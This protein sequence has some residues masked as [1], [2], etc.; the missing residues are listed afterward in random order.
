VDVAPPLN[1]SQ[2]TS[3]LDATSFL[4]TGANP[5]QTGVVSGT[6]ERRR[7]AVLR[8]RVLRR[9][10]S[11][12]PGVHISILDHP[13][14]GQTLTRADGMFD[15]A[16]N[17]GGWLTV[18]YTQ[19]GYLPAQRKVEAPWQEY[20][21]L[22]EVILIQEDAQVTL[23]DLNADLPMQVARGSVITDS[24]GVRQE[25]LFFPQGTTAYMSF[26][27][28]VTQTLTS[29]HVRI[30]E[31][32]VG[33]DG[34]KRMP[35]ELP[36]NSAY[37]YAAEYS[38]DEARAAG[39]QDVWFNPPIIS[40]V[41]NYLSFTVGVTIPMGYYDNDRGAWI[42]ADSGRVVKIVSVTDGRAD[43]DID[44]SGAPA[45]PAA[46]AALGVTDA[47]RAQLAELYAVGESLWR[48]P[49]PHFTR[50]W[51][52]NQGT[53]C[54]EPCP[55]PPEPEPCESAGDNSASCESPPPPP[56]DP[57]IQCGSVIGC[58]NQTLG[59]AIGV[60]GAPFQLHYQ[61][62][63][64]VGYHVPNVLHIPL[65][66]ET[67]SP[68]LQYIQLSVSVAGRRFFVPYISREQRAYQVIWDGKDAAGR[69]VQGRQ[70]VQVALTYIYPLVYRPTD[71]FGYNGNSAVALASDRAALEFGITKRWVGWIGAWRPPVQDLGGWT[72][73]IHHA[74]DPQGKV[75]Y[76]GTGE[77]RS[78][79]ALNGNVIVAAAGTGQACN[80]WI[81]CVEG[82]PATQSRLL[83][84]YGVEFSA[85]GSFYIA[86]HNSST[87]RI[88]RVDASGI[89]TTAAGG[90]TCEENCEG[91]LA[92]QVDLDEPVAVGLAADGSFYIAEADGYAPFRLLKVNKDGTVRTVAGAGPYGSNGDGGPAT[93]ATIGQVW[94]VVVAPD[95]AVYFA[96]DSGQARI[97]RIG[98]DG[99][100]TTVAGG[101]GLPPT[102]G[103]VPTEL[104]TP[105][106][107]SL[108]LGSDGR[109][110]FAFF[111]WNHTQIGVVD[112]A[113]RYFTVARG[114]I[115]HMALGFDG[116]I[117]YT[118][119]NNVYRVSAIAPDG[120]LRTVA[121]SGVRCLG[122]YEG[123]H[124]C[125]NNGP[126]LGAGFSEGLTGIALAPD[127]SLYVA[128]FIQAQVRQIK[129]ALPGVGV[130]DI[131]I[132]STD[133]AQ[134]YVFNA[135]GRHLRTLHGLTG[136]LLYQFDYDSAGRLISVTDGDNNITAITRDG[137]GNPTGILA[138]FGQTTTFA[139]NANGYLAAVTNPANETI[140]LSYTS[141]GLLTGF[142][143]PLH[144]LHTFE[145]DAS[146]RLL[147]DND[148]AA[149]A[150]TLARSAGA[151]TYTVTLTTAL[152][153][154]TY[155]RVEALP[156]DGQRRVNTGPAGLQEETVQTNDGTS[157]DRSPTGVTQNATLGPDPRWGMLA[158]IGKT[159]VITTPGGLNASL[160]G[161]RTAT[162]AQAGDPFSLTAL[163]EIFTV[164]NRTY[165]SSYDTATRTF[166]DASPAGRQQTT[167][168]DVLGRP[169][170]AQ[171]PGLEA[172]TYAY[173]SRG[174]LTAVTQGS[175]PA[176]RSATFAYNSDSY[177]ASIADPLGRTVSFAYDL[178]GRVTTQTLPD[179]RV[180]GYAYDANGNLTS[181]TPPGRPAHTFTYTPV[182]LQASYTPPDIG[183][184]ATATG[185]T[186]NLDRQLTRVTRPDGKTIE[187][188]YDFA[189]RPQSLTFSRGSL[190][191]AYHPTTGNLAGV[192]APGGVSLT[193][194]YD[195]SL[196][197]DQTWTGP[198]AGSVGYIYDNSFRRA[199]LSVNGADAIAY[200]Y[201][202]DSLLTGAGGLILSR[203]AQNGLLVG[204]GLGGVTDAFG[205][206]G[207]G[208]PISYTASF[209]GG[210]LLGFR[211]EYDKLG[212]IV[213]RTETI[214]GAADVYVYGY[215]LAGR[216][217]TVR[218]NGAS[219]STYTYDA[220]GNRLSFTGAGGPVAGTYDAQDRLLIYGNAVYTYSANGELQ[221][222]T[223]GGQSATYAYDELGNLTAFSLPDGTQI[224]YV[225]DGLNRRIGKRVNGVLVQGF[226]YDGQLRIVAELDGAG[227]V[228][229]RFVYAT[230]VN[231]PDYMVKGGVTWRLLTDHLGS[232]RLVVDAATGAVAQAMSFDEFGRVLSD[233][234]P[235]FQP[236][237]FAG[238]LYDRHTGLVRF[239]ARDY[240]AEVGRWTAKD[241]IGFED[242][243]DLYQYVR[244]DPVNWFD[245]FGTWS[246][247][248]SIYAG[249]GG[250]LMV[251][252]DAHYGLA[253]GY[254]LGVGKGLSVEWD[255]DAKPFIY[256]PSGDSLATLFAELQGRLGSTRGKVRFESNECTPGEFGPLEFKPKL[257]SGPLCFGSSGATVRAN[258]DDSFLQNLGH[259][260]AGSI[261][262]K[263]GVRVQFPIWIPVESPY[264]PQFSAS[265]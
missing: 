213:T 107:W 179:G 199:S 51:D 80:T 40:Y 216:L 203:S 188:G 122:P 37:T 153:M 17:G 171:T 239:G 81:P 2:F 161:Q 110:Y 21:W 55:E 151:N 131:L 196:L 23:I 214:S 41:E 155:Y 106:I 178:A 246:V 254:E 77:R 223:V 241:P 119:P 60:V 30:T 207:F 226:L 11:A 7:V 66:G 198:V 9:D 227:A 102:D 46:L 48:V 177:L 240:D 208:E 215:D 166:T 184:G 32:T 244:N 220:N 111:S 98:T 8:G 195:G 259:E 103:M 65:R 33:P 157:V 79:Q 76:L 265:R 27:G 63:R 70:P 101:G 224:E 173:D 74:Y 20:A 16:V 1:P 205:H 209:G 256:G 93:Q 133:G 59:E 64:T 44:G 163:Q 14:F 132:P 217:A 24:D 18:N 126:A 26:A 147:R 36:P 100:I 255:P 73:D 25:T 186:Y 91:L 13:E 117:Y 78:A 162:L 47:E 5:I 159:T 172:L 52:K 134:V 68:K 185:Y 115:G 261:Q 6:M 99:I 129:P 175:G 245:P 35:A 108:A 95:G 148:P 250:G 194:G 137:A 123:T 38:A 118:S 128:D 104:S 89:I 69:T 230:H 232:P 82:I 193:L 146:G 181:L 156:N 210:A 231:V 42:A 130:S 200:S 145:Y 121:G 62:D 3:L 53:S 136:A 120:T 43:L 127:G 235:G 135:A 197:T 96:D 204:T 233:T 258:P 138:P 169:V 219:L 206:N 252:Y 201:D 152:S 90:G 140:Q 167:T 139:R 192:L 49:V 71:R 85:D 257:C 116:T 39:A 45:S 264:Y 15:L 83:H 114:P 144:N 56:D 109:L 75:L 211:Y 242:I 168:I 247:S 54:E 150:M 189:G 94:D 67:V 190:V 234:N 248:V 143:D 164:N 249:I 182:D 34:Q 238:G 105:D 187:I 4:Y 237:G 222:R 92:T 218:K 22:P 31:Y 221:S 149:G 57:D 174:R 58:Q 260:S 251:A 112:V 124:E 50:P 158:P 125:G 160:T 176:A 154:T 29:L 191:Y 61:S 262:G 180:V 202:N 72:L 263:V 183:I 28:G 19:T 236:F 141:D 113:G 165:I 170:L 88:R 87:S 10:G 228:V 212:R 225:I 86:E 243:I 253:G 97:R 229:S 142:Q 84:P 12:L